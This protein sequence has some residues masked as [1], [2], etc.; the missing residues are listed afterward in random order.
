MRKTISI[1]LLAGA[2]TVC[3]A[4]ASMAAPAAAAARRGQANGGDSRVRPVHA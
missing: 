1:A 2:A 4:G 3:P